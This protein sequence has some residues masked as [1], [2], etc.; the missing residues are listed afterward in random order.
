MV[1]ATYRVKNGRTLEGDT[2][3]VG[4]CK[5][6]VRAARVLLR[7]NQSWARQRDRED[8]IETVPR[9]DHKSR[10]TIEETGWI[11]Q[12]FFQRGACLQRSAASLAKGDP[13]S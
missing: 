8:Q 6:A 10:I 7:N 5:D 13:L 4:A 9:F 12:L 2:Q 3:V 11:R 1:A